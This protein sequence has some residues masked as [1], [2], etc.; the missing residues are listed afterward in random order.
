MF[1]FKSNY[2]LKLTVEQ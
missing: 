1:K 2:V